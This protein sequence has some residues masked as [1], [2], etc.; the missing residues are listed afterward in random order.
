MVEQKIARAIQESRQAVGHLLEAHEE[1]LIH[2]LY[3]WGAARYRPKIVFRTVATQN[4]VGENG[5]LGG[6]DGLAGEKS[7]HVPLRVRKRV[8][9]TRSDAE[10]GGI[11]G[12]PSIR[13]ETRAQ[14][15]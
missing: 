1:Q 5:R 12:C 2:G 3:V 15:D 8:V 13:H 11:P 10:E 9:A 4:L 7:I 6:E 14:G